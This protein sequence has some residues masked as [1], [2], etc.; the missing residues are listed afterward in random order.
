MFS[1]PIGRYFLFVCPFVVA[2]KQ[3][4][5]FLFSKE[6]RHFA[7]WL[8][9]NI[10]SVRP[11]AVRSFLCGFAKCFRSHFDKKPDNTHKHSLT[12]WPFLAITHKHYSSPRVF[13][14]PPQKRP[15]RFPNYC[16][17]DRIHLCCALFRSRFAPHMGVVYYICDLASVLS[18]WGF[19]ITGC[20]F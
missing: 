7:L 1:L 4:G 12:S 13:R 14:T 15:L 10:E 9:F 2:S 6:R 5:A 16:V 17:S 3:K 18:F 8:R 20:M 19:G 11:W